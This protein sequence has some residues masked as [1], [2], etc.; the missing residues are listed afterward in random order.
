[1]T[2]IEE[3]TIAAEV[4]EVY[5]FLRAHPT[6]SA[7]RRKD[8]LRASV[9]FTPFGYV[10]AG[11]VSRVAAQSIDAR[12]KESNKWPC[13]GLQRD[14][15]HT[16]KSTA[17]YFFNRPMMAKEEFWGELKRRCE[18]CLVTKPEHS[19]VSMLQ[20]KGHGL[21]AYDLAGVQLLLV[22]R[23]AVKP[24]GN[25]AELVRAFWPSSRQR[26]PCKLEESSMQLR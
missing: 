14:H 9:E 18:Y 5:R 15:F 22:D 25:R 16:W 23:R 17:E 2:D 1:M 7:N 6:M 11:K 19:R 4:W 26:V 10:F 13:L 12:L 20:R 21:D 8:I 24:A 3:Q